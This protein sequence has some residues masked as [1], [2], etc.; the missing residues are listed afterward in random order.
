MVLRMKRLADMKRK[1][2]GKFSELKND[3][4]SW[5]QRSQKQI[6][7]SWNSEAPLVSISC[8]TY[9][10]AEYIEQ[11][12]QGFLMQETSF[13]YEVIIH[14]DASTDGTADI[15][16]QYEMEYPQIIKSIY[17]LTNQRADKNSD[18]LIQL[19]DLMNGKYIAFCEGDDYWSDA[20]KLQKQFDFL[21]NNEA[22]FAVGTLTRVICKKEDKNNTF[23]D[24][25]AGEYGIKDL[26]KWRLFAHFSSYFTRNFSKLMSREDLRK[27]LDV[28]CPGDRKFPF[29]FLQYGRLY[30]L[31]FE[32]S[33][34]RFKS[35]VQCFTMSK[36]YGNRLIHWEECNEV[37]KY[38]A[39]VG[40]NFDRRRREREILMHLLIDDFLGKDS[41]TYKKIKRIRNTIRHFFKM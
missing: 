24:T 3:G 28:K 25:K 4:I 7:G 37:A 29:L 19:Y 18:I 30:V 36:D 13:P 8:L 17:E 39:S 20:H 2:T 9:N 10:H 27:Y 35:G 22:F 16:R 12:L 32:G 6:M 14:D 21:E 31:P 33:T 41:E 34:Y 1:Q 40:V 15:I 23:I 26:N 11:C 5:G 38:A